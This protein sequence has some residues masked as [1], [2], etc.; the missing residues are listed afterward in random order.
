[1]KLT[2]ISAIAAALLLSACT[3]HDLLQQQ[4][5]EDQAL[6]SLH[7]SERKAARADQTAIVAKAAAVA[8]DQRADATKQAQSDAQSN[9]EQVMSQGGRN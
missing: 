9:F 1:M 2:F 5:K 3:P 8:A 6:N 7:Q 4:V